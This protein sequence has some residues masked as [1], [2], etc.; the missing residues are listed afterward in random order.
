MQINAETWEL[1]NNA[2]KHSLKGG[3]ALTYTEMVEGIREYLRK[4]KINFPQSVEWYAVTVKHDLHVRGILKV[5][6]EKGRK[7]HMLN[8]E[9]L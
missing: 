2:I 5:F 6:T 4:N 7:L 3:K 9:A 8:K 1:F